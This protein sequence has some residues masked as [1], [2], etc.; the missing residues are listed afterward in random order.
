MA[1]AKQVRVEATPHAEALLADLLVAPYEQLSALPETKT[2][3][4]EGFSKPV[5]LTTYRDVRPDGSVQV[6]VQLAVSGWLGSA[7]FWVEGF[8]LEQGRSPV[9][10]TPEQLYDFH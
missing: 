6:V 1:S 8:T 2:R 10:L 5:A 7:S 3:Q 4:L 9:R